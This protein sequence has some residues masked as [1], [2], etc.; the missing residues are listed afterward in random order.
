MATF[1]SAFSRSDPRR[2]TGPDGAFDYRNLA[3]N[4][5]TD[6]KKKKSTKGE[7]AKLTSDATTRPLCKLAP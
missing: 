2:F 3:I 1:S 4:Q 5:A 6:H 7:K